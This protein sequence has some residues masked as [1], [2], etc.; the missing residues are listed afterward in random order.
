MSIDAIAALAAEAKSGPDTPEWPVIAAALGD[1]LDDVLAEPDVLRQVV[2]ALVDVA[3]AHD[4][5]AVL[6]ASMAG[7][8]IAGAAVANAQNGLRAFGKR[9]PAERVVVIDGLLAT[10][11]NLARA[12]EAAREQGA[13]IVVAV[14]V[15]SARADVPEIPGASG[16]VV[17]SPAPA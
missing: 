15:T 5:H 14:A 17:L 12:V 16:V 9:T 6:G 10:G 4:A 11:V 8:L 1:R 3:T 7:A 13:Q 2:E